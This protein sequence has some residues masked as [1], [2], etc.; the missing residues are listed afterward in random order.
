MRWR[1]SSHSNPDGP[2]CVEISG[3]HKSSYSTN[4]GDCVEAA[5]GR[6]VLIRDTQNRELGHLTFASPEWAGLLST[7]K[8]RQP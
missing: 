1:K 7:L 2:Q 5:E 4:G 8:A 6:S 3:W